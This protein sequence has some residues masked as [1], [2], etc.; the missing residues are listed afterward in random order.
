LK[1]TTLCLG[2]GC[3]TEVAYEEMNCA[4]PFVTADYEDPLSLGV[5]QPGCDGWDMCEDG[6]SPPCGEEPP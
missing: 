6:L 4:V 5:G 1:Q 3:F 2:A